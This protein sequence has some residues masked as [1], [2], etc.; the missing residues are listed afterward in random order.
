MAL[1]RNMILSMVASLTSPPTSD[2]MGITQFNNILFLGDSITHGEGA[3]TLAGGF[4]NLTRLLLQSQRGGNQGE[5][6]VPMFRTDRWTLAG[7]WGG[8]GYGPFAA[9]ISSSVSG[10][11]ATATMVGTSFDVFFVKTSATAA[12]TVQIDSETP[13]SI[14]GSNASP[15]FSQANVASVIGGGSHTIKI[16]APT[17]GT[18]FLWGVSANDGV[19]G[20]R[21]HN[22]GNHGKFASDAAASNDFASLT[23]WIG[24]LAPDLT[25]ITFGV[26]DYASA[27]GVSAFT[28][29]MQQ[30][31]TAAK[32][33]G[34]VALIAQNPVG[35]VASPAQSAYV[36]AIASLATSNGVL[37]YAD[38][39]TR[40]GATYPKAALLGFINTSDKTHPT[41]TGHADYAAVVE[42]ALGIAPASVLPAAGTPADITQLGTDLAAV[43]GTMLGIYDVR[44]AGLVYDTGIS[45][46][47]DARGAVGF[48]PSFTQ[49]ATARQPDWVPGTDAQKFI[50]FTDAAGRSMATAAVSAYD[51]V[52]ALTFIA[53]GVLPIPTANAYL[54]GINDS[55]SVLGAMLI[56]H[57][58]AGGISGQ[59]FPSGTALSTTVLPSTTRRIVYV[60][61][62][63]STTGNAE[64]PSQGKKNT[65]ITAIA[66]RNCAA[67]LGQYWDTHGAAGGF[68]ARAILILSGDYTTAQRDII[69]AWAVANHGAVLA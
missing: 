47:D 52:N 49:P 11:T 1:L 4:E 8:G 7:T 34:P 19:G 28:T 35:A 68:K 48:G 53:V 33:I 37:W 65:A 3:T 27:V 31:I 43:G 20:V 30:L 51:L 32:A 21:C 63:A 17:S 46:W 5:G 22:I 2:P 57:L 25:V 56:E 54:G 23:G 60:S 59:Y 44:A 61:K 62:N 14:G 26:N 39:F 50:V 18:V 6:C 40:W 24:S 69:D 12:F 67:V 41:D 38:M 16:T 42:G 29:A 10:S 9:S 45:N 15:L 58:T 55:A 13:I 66:T 64:T 36:A